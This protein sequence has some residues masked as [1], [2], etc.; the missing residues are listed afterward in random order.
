ME[1]MS[2]ELGKTGGS[3]MSTFSLTSN[4]VFNTK[5]TIKYINNSI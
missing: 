2:T 3:F 4:L 1:N 5:K